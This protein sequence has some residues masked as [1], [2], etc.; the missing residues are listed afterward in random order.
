V[1]AAAV[2]AGRV[3]EAAVVGHAAGGVRAR[4]RANVAS[5][6]TRSDRRRPRRPWGD[7]PWDVVPLVPPALEEIREVAGLR[8]EASVAAPSRSR[9]STHAVGLNTGPSFEPDPVGLGR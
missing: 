5:A 7:V 3:A 8:S 4:F 9:R 2:D 1:V 6:E